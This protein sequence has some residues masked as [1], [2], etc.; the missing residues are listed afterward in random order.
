MT[1]KT[2]GAAFHLDNVGFG[3]KASDYY[4]SDGTSMAAP[5]VSGVAALAAMVYGAD[6]GDDAGEIRARIIGAVEPGGWNRFR[7]QV[8]IRRFSGCRGRFR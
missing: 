3:K 6:N 7:G 2:E 5:A 1:G 4:Y 8:S